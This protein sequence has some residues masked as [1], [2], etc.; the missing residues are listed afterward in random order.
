[1]KRILFMEKFYE[2]RRK[3]AGKGV[4]MREYIATLPKEEAVILKRIC[5]VRNEFAFNANYNNKHEVE[6][7]TW[8]AFLEKLIVENL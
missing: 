7:E 2:L 5:D 3:L 4:S 8:I 6:I 1:M